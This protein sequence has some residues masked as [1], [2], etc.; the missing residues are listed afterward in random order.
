MTT[1]TA[2]YNQVMDAAWKLQ[3][4]FRPDG[5]YICVSTIGGVVSCDVNWSSL[6]AKSPADA[7]RFHEAL[8]EAIEAAE[9]FEF[10]G[11]EV[12]SEMRNDDE[13]HDGECEERDDISA[14]QDLTETPMTTADL[15]D[16]LGDWM[17]LYDVDALLDRISEMDPAT[18]A[19]YECDGEITGDDL[20]ACEWDCDVRHVE[21]IAETLRL[22]E[23]LDVD[24]YLDD[25]AAFAALTQER[26]GKHVWLSGL[27]DDEVLGI[28]Y[29]CVRAKH[30]ERPSVDATC[31]A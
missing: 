24:E 16:L 10:A 8:G 13:G 28:L 20:E 21:D 22:Y 3:E 14:S 30:Y 26:D 1:K 2:T 31:G 15:S 23:S 7:R 19:R 5:I 12:V 9:S 4:R 18:G 27:V 29:A 6:G 25:E 17:W 11:C